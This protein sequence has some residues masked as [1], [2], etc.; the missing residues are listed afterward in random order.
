MASLPFQPEEEEVL[1]HIVKQASQ[2]REFLQK[3]T[4][5]ACTTSEEVPTLIFY[6][7]KIEGAE[8]LLAYETNF[9]RQEI[10]KWAP[11]APEPPPILEQ[12]LSTRKPRPTKS[13]K[14]MAQLGVERV[15][16]LPPHLRPKASHANK[17]KSM[18]ASQ[19]S[20]PQQPTTGTDDATGE[21]QQTVT[22]GSE[23]VLP[24]GSNHFF[25]G[26]ANQARESSPSLLLS[27]TPEPGP[28][29]AQ[30]AAQSPPFP[31]RSPRG[32]DQPL[33]SAPSAF[34]NQQEGVT[35]VDM[36]TSN[37]FGSSPPRQEINDVFAALTN[38][39]ADN[40]ELMENTHANEALEALDVSNGRE[41]HDIGNDDEPS[42][43]VDDGNRGDG[44]DEF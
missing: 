20:R 33:F 3:Y 4:N 40:V 14:I 31:P 12:S 17:R 5:P 41:A 1:E 11:V 43:S 37:P 19:S 26:Y 23:A 21:N 39:D 15:E 24:V 28:L 7:R 25:G 35:G 2:F 34:R 44:T 30:A 13:Q 6:L 9:F 8:V 10:H 16:D 38:E 22:G 27:S 18:D 32:L 42:A 29:L 36:E